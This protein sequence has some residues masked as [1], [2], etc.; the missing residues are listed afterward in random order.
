MESNNVTSQNKV[1]SKLPE[2]LGGIINSTCGTA[3]VK[4][5]AVAPA[6][7]PA[8]PAVEQQREPVAT[9]CPATGEVESVVDEMLSQG[10][11][12]LLLRPQLIKNLTQKQLSRSRTALSEGMCLVPEGQV[13]IRHN[14]A[15]AEGETEATPMQGPSLR[16]EAYY[17]DRYPVTNAQFHQFVASGGYEEMAI[18]DPEIWPALLDFV[19]ATG[20]PGPRY[21]RDGR[22]PRSED[23]HPVIGV[24]WYEA[25]AYS[26]WIGKR[27]PTDAEWVKAGSWPVSIQGH[28]L[29]LRRYPWGEAMDRGRANLWG[30]GPGRTV[31]I[32]E[33][34]GGVSVGGVH[35]L[36]GNVW[37]WTAG[38]F[39]L[40]G[41]EASGAMLQTKMKSIRG[42]AFDTYL[43]SQ[44][45]C[46]FDSADVAPARKHNIGFRCAISLCDLTV[47]PEES[48]E[49]SQEE[50]DQ[51]ETSFA[52][53]QT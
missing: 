12:T 32:Y 19:D 17:L 31:S 41:I 24:S 42:G 33:F 36:I 9:E 50:E 4:E 25:L 18:W 44:A 35:Q 29:L 51:I 40:D 13:A 52:E 6:E 49:G 34:P 7:Q 20:H 45:T 11:Y 28:P 47:T 22:F 53:N 10:R 30:S 21:W 8:A 1:L 38:A 37:E 5:Q 15:P 16:V 43:D 23:N 48:A 46:H 27:L 14:W 26:R 39:A 2:W 3:R